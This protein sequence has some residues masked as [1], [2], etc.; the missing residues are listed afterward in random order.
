M[1][2]SGREGNGGGKGVGCVVGREE[3]GGGREKGRHWEGNCN[4][5]PISK[6]IVERITIVLTLQSPFHTSLTYTHNHIITKKSW[7]L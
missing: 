2:G 4:L 6:K 3:G 5:Y 1:T 7:L